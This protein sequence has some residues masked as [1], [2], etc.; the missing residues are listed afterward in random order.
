MVINGKYVYSSVLRARMPLLPSRQEACEGKRL[1][2]E[3]AHVTVPER[4]NP[5][6]EHSEPI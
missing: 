3:W 6:V 4:M 2:V 5:F 1:T